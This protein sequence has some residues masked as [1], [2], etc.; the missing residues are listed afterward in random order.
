MLAVGGGGHRSFTGGGADITQVY[1]RNQDATL[2]IGNLDSQ[3]DDDLLWELFVQ[4]GPVRTVS[5]PR[6]K[7]TGNHQ[8]YGFVEFRNEVD[9]DYA[10]KLMNMVKLYG[11]ALRLNKSAQDRRNFD[12]GANVFLG[13]LDPDVDE[14]TIYDTFSAFGNII[15]AKIMR[16]PETGLSR[17]FGFVSFDTFEASDAAL[18]AM[19][20]QFICN[21]PIH[22][23][24]AYK[25][26]TRGERHGS[27]A[28]RLL[29]ANRP[30][31]INPN[32]PA[33]GGV[34][35][36]IS[37]AMQ[38]GTQGQGTGGVI[39]GGGGLSSVP[40]PPLLG[41][42]PPRGPPGAQGFPQSF[43]PHRGGSGPGV[44][45]SGPPGG[46]PGSASTGPG[47][48][49]GELPP[50]PLPP[51]MAGGMPNLPMGLPPPPLLFM[52]RPGMPPFPPM[53]N[54]S[55]VSQGAG[56]GPPGSSPQGPPGPGGPP[57]SQGMPPARA[58]GIP[59]ITPL[60]TPGSAMGPLGPESPSG[61]GAG[62]SGAPRP[63]PGGIPPPG[64]VSPVRPD[65]LPPPPLILSAG[66]PGSGSHA[67]RGP[68]VFS[69][70][71]NMRPPMGPH[72][73]ALLGPPPGASP[74][75][76]SPMPGLMGRGP[77][78]GGPPPLIPQ[79]GQQPNRPPMMG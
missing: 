23:S 36:P 18:A 51:N 70:S 53:P 50:L 10:L 14:K 39:P 11:K 56:M 38:S 69:P 40:P 65:L 74:N 13:N 79:G 54:M 19:N 64:G 76:R 21:R 42:M 66:G 17:G 75:M 5:V 9:A 77:A 58:P 31:I 3:V 62:G 7:L 34:K 63:S 45:P 29:A 35:P 59:T 2:Y 28:E 12:V 52:P 16:D 27:A 78:A 46:A 22:V 73:G 8:G 32:A 47:G 25:K 4:C 6:D 49:M 15:S 26:D 57:S 67:S 61:P 44:G 33:T 43:G 37:L 24:Y 30:Q 68:A 55:P 41:A 20:G 1:E 48:R 60:R 72:G 71:P